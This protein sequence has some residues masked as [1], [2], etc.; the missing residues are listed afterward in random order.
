M[1]VATTRSTER[2]QFL[3]YVF[4]AALEGGIGYWSLCHKFHWQ[5]RGVPKEALFD[6]KVDWDGFYAII[7]EAEEG[8]WSLAGQKP[9]VRVDADVIEKGI[10][11]LASGK[12]KLGNVVLGRILA[13]SAQAEAGDIDSEAADCI[14][15][16]AVLGE[17][18]YG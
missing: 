4:S 11:L 7:E 1:T 8:D 5:K 17:V 9:Q 10:E 6:D 12:V 14:I 2:Q 18:R 13:G 15:Q 16:A 3:F